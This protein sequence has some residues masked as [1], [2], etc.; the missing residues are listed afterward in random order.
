MSR[1][2]KLSGLKI[3]KWGTGLLILLVSATW[4]CNYWV[5]SSTRSQ[6]YNSVESVPFRRVGLL[7]GTNKTWHGIENPFFKNRIDAAV[8]LYKAGKIKHIIVSGDNHLSYYDEAKFMK[9][10]LIKQG[11]PDSCITLDY[12]GFRTLDSMVRCFEIFGQDSVTV[13][14]QAFHNERAIFIA[15][16]YNKHAIG[17]NALDPPSMFSVQTK[18]REY[19]AKFKAVLD[20]YVLHTTPHF[21][22]EKIKI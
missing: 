15:N 4:L 8:A 1:L 10:S 22:G 2:K 16:Y 7:L 13:I 14:S 12:A 11:V 6:L 3:V 20:L 18:I 5:I 19:F 17:Y 21:L 9:D